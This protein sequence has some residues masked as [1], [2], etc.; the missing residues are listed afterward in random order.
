MNAVQKTSFERGKLYQVR[1][2]HKH[3]ANRIGVFQ[4]MGGPEKDTVVLADLDNG[5]VFFCVAASDLTLP[6]FQTQLHR[7]ERR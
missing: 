4:F 2:N 7:K 5:Q 1:Q 3:W 6:M